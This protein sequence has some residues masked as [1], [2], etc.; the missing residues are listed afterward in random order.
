MNFEHEPTL[1]AEK[2]ADYAALDEA[3]FTPDDS[4]EKIIGKLKEISLKKKAIADVQNSIIDEYIARFEEG[5]ETLNA[6]AVEKLQAMTD[7]L[8]DPQGG[9][10]MDAPISLRL[11]KLLYEYY[12]KKEDLENA[13]NI[14][15]TGAYC[16]L[17]ISMDLEEHDFF[18]FPKLCEEYL[19]LIDRLSPKAQGYLLKAYSYRIMV[20]TDSGMRSVPDIFISVE[21]NISTCIKKTGITEQ[22]GYLPLYI[23]TNFI[24][25]MTMALTQDA[26]DKKHGLNPRHDIELEKYRSILERSLQEA[27]EGLKSL[28]PNPMNQLAVL[29][30][31]ILIRFHLGHI[32]FEEL[33]KELYDLGASMSNTPYE[34]PYLL[35]ATSFYLNYTFACSPY[36]PEEDERIARKIIDAV[37]PKIL[38]LNKVNDARF[39][40]LILQFINATSRFGTFDEFYDI[41][42]AFTVYADKAL[43]VHTV[44]VKEISHL[45]LEYL[46]DE[47]PEY[48][49]GVCGYDTEYIKNHRDEMLGIMDKCAMCHDIGK[50]FLIEIVSNSSRRLTDDEYNIIKNHP[51]NFGIVFENDTHDTPQIKCIRDCALLHHRWHNGQGG[52]PEIPQTHNR[53]FVDILSIADSLDAATD[54]I[55]RPYGT[56]KTLDDLIAEFIDMGGTR[57]SLE[58]A[59][60]LKKP[61][62][63]DAVS[64]IITDRRG[65]V[66]YKIYA[67]NE[68]ET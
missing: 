9:F 47:N 64:K 24:A 42:L 57:Y 14:I 62:I 34:S 29:L 41:V 36:S 68:I 48:L 28:P 37:I 12:H 53:P 30:N 52:Y 8:T 1:Y 26:E 13:V 32:T 58:V 7:S 15:R 11:A 16:E 35:S 51:Q 17:Q 4:K 3:E 19:P 10:S 65:E 25:M 61:E 46:L 67:F 21:K 44:M 5:R 39:S 23:H 43:Y 66:N 40:T 59:E 63:H 55:G 38:A 60:L 50:H 33:G 56:G 20:K 45:L 2:L 18:Y 31:N 6:D 49:D 27:E 54:Y 22:M